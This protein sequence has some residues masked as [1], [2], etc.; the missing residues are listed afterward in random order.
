MLD[1]KPGQSE[2][3]GDTTVNPPVISAPTGPARVRASPMRVGVAT[4][5]PFEVSGEDTASASM[6]SC[7]PR[8]PRLMEMLP[9]TVH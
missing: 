2:L 4:E 8:A 3:P 6:D 9:G 5:G 1:H 7:W